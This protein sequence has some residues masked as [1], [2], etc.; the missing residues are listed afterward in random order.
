MNRNPLT[1]DELVKHLSYDASTGEFR[2][3]SPKRYGVIGTVA[4]TNQNGYVLIRINR[5]GHLAHRLAWLYVY[6]EFPKYGIDH[7]NRNG[8]DNRISNLRVATMQQNMENKSVYK[9]NKS[10][11]LGV[12]PVGNKFAAK[13]CKHHKQYYL[14]L[15]DTAELASDAYKQAKKRHHT[16]NPRMEQ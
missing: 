12:Y 8:M 2:W 11:Y 6:G 5:R 4:G 13:I 15:F 10:G 1:R 3:I 16:F 14:G 7:I 9:R